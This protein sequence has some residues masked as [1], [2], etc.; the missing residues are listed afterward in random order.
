M[1]YRIFKKR[2]MNRLVMTNEDEIPWANATE[3]K[4]VIQGQTTPFMVNAN[5][6]R[7]QYTQTNATLAVVLSAIG[8]V[9]MVGSGPGICCAIPAIILA[10]GA[11]AITNSQPGHPD[12]S[13]AKAAQIIGW[14]VIGLTIAIILFLILVIGGLGGLGLVLGN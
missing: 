11:L 5:S 3:E 13:T 12:A 7:G 6:P 14:I 8:A 10:N 4:S 2:M 1:Q 9:L